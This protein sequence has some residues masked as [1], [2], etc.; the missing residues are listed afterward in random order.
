[1]CLIISH[2]ATL[3]LADHHNSGFY[4]FSIH[5]D[6]MVWWRDRLVVWCQTRPSISP[7]QKGAS[8]PTLQPV[9]IPDS[10]QGCFPYHVEGLEH[11]VFDKIEAFEICFE[12]AI[13][14]IETQANFSLCYSSLGGGNTISASVSR[15][16]WRTDRQPPTYSRKG[17]KQALCIQDEAA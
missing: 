7:N 2:A 5:F 8:D 11:T 14:T 4:F 1:M 9:G 13:P 6:W 16:T 10:L 3:E 12:E 15:D 17:L